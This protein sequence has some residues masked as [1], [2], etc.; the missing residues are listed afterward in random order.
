VDAGGLSN[1]ELQ[2]TVSRIAK[3]AAD[4][5]R[6]VLDT[7]AQNYLGELVATAAERLQDDPTPEQLARAEDSFVRLAQELGQPA[8]TRRSR[9]TEIRRARTDVVTGSQIEAALSGLCPG[10]WP[11]C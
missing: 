8:R 1:T 5:Q 11:F 3:E 7:S 6:L 4:R 9:E 2:N 10:F